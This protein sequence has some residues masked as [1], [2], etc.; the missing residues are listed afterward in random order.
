MIDIY[1]FSDDGNIVVGIVGDNYMVI[2]F[3]TTKIKFALIGMEMWVFEY[4]YF[5]SFF[6]STQQSWMIEVLNI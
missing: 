5:W 4:V 6:F 3:C 2:K 1:K